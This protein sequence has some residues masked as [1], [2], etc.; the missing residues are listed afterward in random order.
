M[1]LTVGVILAPG[2]ASKS[3][4]VCSIFEAFRGVSV[5]GAIQSSAIA[6]F[7]TAALQHRFDKGRKYFSGGK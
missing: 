5:T 7:S 4:A 1:T 6:R 2:R 3:K